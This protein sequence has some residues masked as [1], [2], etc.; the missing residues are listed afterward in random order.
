V[1]FCHVVRS[2]CCR[3]D[4]KRHSRGDRGKTAIS[5][6]RAEKARR[7]WLVSSP[8]LRYDPGVLVSRKTLGDPPFEANGCSGVCPRGLVPAA[9]ARG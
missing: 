7:L 8:G 5:G 6:A 3:G 2:F 4:G 1:A 9:R